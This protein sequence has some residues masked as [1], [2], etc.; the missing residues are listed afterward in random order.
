M[1]V[2]FG[3]AFN[4]PTIAHKEIY[5][6]IKKYVDFDK[7]IYLPVSNLYTKSSLIANVH[8]INMLE[9]MVSEMDNAYVSDLETVDSDFMGTYHS[10]LRLQEKYDDEIAF[11]IGADNLFNI[12]DWKN[13]LSLLAEFKFIVINRDRLDIDAFL[14]KNKILAKNKDHFIILPGFDMNISSTIFRET[15]EPSYVPEQVFDYIMT[16]GLY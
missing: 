10:L 8:R 7:F 5:F 13:S 4:P 16:H 12:H 11:V 1:V 15:F 2:V 9:L 3:G 14:E 6:H